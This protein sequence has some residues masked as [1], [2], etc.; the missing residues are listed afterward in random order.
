MA[1]LE[2]PS[3]RRSLSSAEKNLISKNENIFPS[4]NRASSSLIP[5]SSLLK[6]KQQTR[7]EFRDAAAQREI[8]RSIVRKGQFTRYKPNFRF[9]RA[10]LFRFVEKSS[11]LSVELRVRDHRNGLVFAKAKLRI[12]PQRREKNLPLASRDL[13]G[14]LRDMQNGKAQRKQKRER[15]R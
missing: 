1:L 2:K 4:S 15:V 12:W 8:D 6:R 13:R 7:D 11:R 3:S 14:R 10:R 9:S 5:K